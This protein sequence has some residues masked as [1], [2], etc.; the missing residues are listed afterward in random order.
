M[1]CFQP[2]N[3]AGLCPPDLSGAPDT[4][5]QGGAGMWAEDVSGHGLSGG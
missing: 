3:P 1:S 5:G 4:A 2:Q